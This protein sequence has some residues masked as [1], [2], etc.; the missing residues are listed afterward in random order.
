M[1]FLVVA[2]KSIF[3]VQDFSAAYTVL[4]MRRLGLDK[5][6]GQDIGQLTQLTKGILDTIWHYALQ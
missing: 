3:R 1:V 2:E 6:L 4:P 5:K